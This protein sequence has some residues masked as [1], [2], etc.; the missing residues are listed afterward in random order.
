MKTV[1]PCN[2]QI[3]RCCGLTCATKPVL[4]KRRSE[5]EVS[6]CTNCAARKLNMNSVLECDQGNCPTAK[7]V[8]LSD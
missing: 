6:Q 5:S 8:L 7:G 1:T 4:C 3:A 2:I